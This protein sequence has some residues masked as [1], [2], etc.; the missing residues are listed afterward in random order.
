MTMMKKIFLFLIAFL[1]ASPVAFAQDEFD[2]EEAY[3]E[4]EAPKKKKSI[5]N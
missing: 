4:D 2:D 3:Y 5:F 1:V